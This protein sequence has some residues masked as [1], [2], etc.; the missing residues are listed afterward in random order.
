MFRAAIFL[1]CLFFIIIQEIS[2]VNC[3]KTESLKDFNLIQNFPT[4]SYSNP[5]S[6]KNIYRIEGQLPVENDDYVLD[7]P[8]KIIMVQ[9]NQPG[10]FLAAAIVDD[11]APLTY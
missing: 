10:L 7:P 11:F 5:E 4:D 8:R 6:R 1:W 3:S 2:P 9:T